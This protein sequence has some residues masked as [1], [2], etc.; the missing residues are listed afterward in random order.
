MR[1]IL[2]VVITLVMVT[3]T[4]AV[5]A[6]EGELTITPR[7]AYNYL[8]DGDSRDAVGSNYGVLVDFEWY[9]SPIGLETGY[10]FGNKTYEGVE[11]D[12]KIIP[13]MLTYKDILNEGNLYWK[14][15]AGVAF[16]EFK[17]DS[18]SDKT[19]DTKFAWEALI[20]INLNAATSFELGY[21]DYGKE[22]GIKTGAIQANI[23]FA[24]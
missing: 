8:I 19:K 14:A 9:T 13:V 6:K 7:I 18:T 1:K 24:F 2:I 20:G 15:G 3:S 5:M 10:L 11:T 4:L 12:V 17:D 16:D 23:G 22:N 21:V